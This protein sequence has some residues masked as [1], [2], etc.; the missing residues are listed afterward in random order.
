MKYKKNVKIQMY[1]KTKNLVMRGKYKQWFWEV[2]AVTTWSTSGNY[3]KYKVF[4]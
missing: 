3:E 4:K 1:T 2:Q